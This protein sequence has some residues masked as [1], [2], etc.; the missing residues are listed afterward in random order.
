M[1]AAP[2]FLILYEHTVREYE[3]DLLL[4]LELERRGYTAEIRQLLDA[5]NLRWV[6]GNNKPR[7]LVASCMYDN[8][9]IN[10]HVYNNIG[11]CD[12]IV[13]LHWEQMLS[14]TQEE[15]DWFNM[16]GNAKRC[17]QT[18]WGTRTA[19]R[20]QAHGMEAKNT[21]VTGA[22]MMDFLRPEFKGY[23]KNKDALC[24]EFGLDPEKHLHLYI[25]SFGYASMGEEE[26]AELSRMA[27]TDF[28]GF[29]RTNRVSMAETLRWFERYL[30]AHPEVE[31]VY[32]RHPSEWN[33]P[34]L[35]KLAARCPNFHVIFADSVKQWIVA[36]D[37]ISIWMSTAIAEVYMAGKSCHILRPVPIEHEYD[38]VIY[39]DAA[40]I[41]DYDAFAAAMADPAPPFPIEK[42][43][44]EGYF[45]PSPQPAYRRMADLLETVLREPPRDTPMGDGFT[46]HFN[47][48]KC[49]ALTGVHFLYRRRWQP[50]TVFSFC[51]P[52]ARFAQRIYG[53]VDKAYLAPEEKARMEQRIRPF[54]Q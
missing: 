40:Y 38:P 17:V 5:K 54:V 21:P 24:R 23:F 6:F 25:S 42:A 53:Y 50:K 7:V 12:K 30:T 36:A 18:C 51:P 22:V 11:R 45:D 31:L 13:N 52:L 4:K 35:E 9:A 15:G 34:A 27:G 20:L 29:A 47:L 43:V 39:K 2:D 33:S 49:A 28:T 46:P 16:N 3:S 8:E 37:S 10:S 19:A 1:K 14:G 41:T 32:R 26:V 44:I 48:L